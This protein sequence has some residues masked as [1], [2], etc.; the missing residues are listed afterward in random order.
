MLHEG[1]MNCKLWFI[2]AIFGLLLQILHSFTHVKIKG[3]SNLSMTP[4]ML[5]VLYKLRLSY[6]SWCSY[7]G[8]QKEREQ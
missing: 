3:H 2:A 8:L 6:D 7:L 1:E 4:M 5:T